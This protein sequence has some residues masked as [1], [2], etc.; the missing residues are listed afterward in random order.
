MGN[1]G[2]IMGHLRENYG[3]IM[4]NDGTVPIYLMEYFTN[5][6]AIFLGYTPKLPF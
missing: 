1:D 5:S 2:K 6:N 4:G 3:R